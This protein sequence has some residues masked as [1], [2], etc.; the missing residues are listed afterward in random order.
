M[1]DLHTLTLR[2]I[3]LDGFPVIRA[4]PTTYYNDRVLGKLKD[5]EGENGDE[6]YEIMSVTAT[7]HQVKLDSQ[8]RL[9]IPDDLLKKLNIKKEIRFIGMADFF[10]I[11]QPESCEQFIAARR[12]S[13]ANGQSRNIGN[14]AGSS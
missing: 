9:N 10:D 4:Y 5:L 3:E 2:L 1:Y 13:R 11:W 6:A 12:A 7:C 8:G 14:S